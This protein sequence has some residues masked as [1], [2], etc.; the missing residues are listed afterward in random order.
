LIYCLNHGRRGADYHCGTCQIGLCRDCIAIKDFGKTKLEQCPRCNNPL[1]NLEPYKPA[2]PFWTII[3]ELLAWPFKDEGWMMF[4]GWAV[5]AL[6]MKGLADLGLRVGFIVGGLAAAILA[7]YYALLISYFYRIISRTEDGKF[8]VP[9]WTEFEGLGCSMF[10]P[11]LYYLG[12]CLSV[13]YP[14]LLFLVAALVIKGGDL[15]ALGSVIISPLGLIVII[16]SVILGLPLLPMSL[17]VIGVFRNMKL[18]MNPLFL[19]NQIRKILPEYMMAL[20]LIL[21]MLIA[22]SAIRAVFFLVNRAIGGVLA[23]L[24][25]FPV[26]GMLQLYLFM[27]LGHLLGYMAYQTRYKLKWWPETQEEPVFMVG[28][29]PTPLEWRSRPPL[30]PAVAAPIMAG[31]GAAAAAAVAAQ[32]PAPG[33]GLQ[34]LT[35][36]ISDGMAM[37]EHGRHK[38]ARELF[39]EILDRNPG[40]AAALRGMVIA[41]LGLGDVE[42]AKKY[43][44]KQAGLMAREQSFDLLWDT[45][46]ELKKKIPGFS[47]APRDQ[48]ALAR[49]L[50][51]QG[52]H[53]EAAKALREFAATNPDDP[54]APKALYQCGEI[55]WKSAGK[56]EAARQMFEYILQRYPEVAFAEQVKINISQIK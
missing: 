33:G 50:S 25:V 56:P 38:D 8:D 10:M 32:P 12:A 46:R 31:A 24:M 37:I 55:L 34:D 1:T 35:R 21:G 43:G 3:P 52:N 20:G 17:L 30:T 11:V 15:L 29:K 26:D 42:A 48:L 28:G 5:F 40:H 9:A 23:Y 53:M 19:I 54:M 39:K 44:A 13:F 27:F 41:S 16:I 14:F 47:L 7:A 2:P 18:V 49:W 51:Q 6:V 45:Y 22:Y 4:L 36:K